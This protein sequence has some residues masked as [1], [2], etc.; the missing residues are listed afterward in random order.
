MAATQCYRFDPV[1][2][3]PATRAF[4]QHALALLGASQVPFLVCGSYALQAYI[5]NGRRTK[6]LDI[7]VRPADCPGALQAL[8]A[9][10]Y[11]TEVVFPHWLAKV[12]FAEDFIDVIFSSGNGLCAVDDTWFAHAVRGEVLGMPVQLCPPEEIIWQK[13]FVMERERFDGADVAHLLRAF[14]KDLDWARLLGRFGSHWRVLLAHLILFSFI[15]PSHRS[16]VPEAVLRE[17]LGRLQVE[18]SSPVP[19][20]L[21][22]QGTLLSRAQYL[23]DIE[24]WGYQD[25]RLRPRGRMT[26]EEI[27]LWTAAI[28]EVVPARRL[29]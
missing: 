17:L 14:G 24:R 28:Q 25:A 20:D 11:A 2:L 10:G 23:V 7:F 5:G 3:D 19:R 13:T 6:D 1:E 12:F 9:A 15:Y 27:D 22:C 26:A 16:E 8:S 21:L 18:M 29:G 4:Y